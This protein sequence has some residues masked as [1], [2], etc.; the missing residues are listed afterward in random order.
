MTA[1]PPLVVADKLT[2]YF[3]LSGGRQIHAVDQV[4]LTVHEK[5]VVGLVGESGSGKSTLGKTLIGLHPRTSG[6]ASYR[7]EALPQRY[8]PEDFRRARPG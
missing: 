4:T 3:Q 1:A 5:E 2:K 6:T 8:Q 7:G